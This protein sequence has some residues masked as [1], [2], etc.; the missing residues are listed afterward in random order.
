VNLTRAIAGIVSPI[1]DTRE[2]NVLPRDAG[3]HGVTISQR[4][5]HIADSLLWRRFDISAIVITS[6][7]T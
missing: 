6:A 4:F 3:S 5:E 2:E 7:A 1:G